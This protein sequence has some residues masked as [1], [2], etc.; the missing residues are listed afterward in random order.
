[1]TLERENPWIMS[2]RDMFGNPESHDYKFG[3]DFNMIEKTRRFY[4]LKDETLVMKKHVNMKVDLMADQAERDYTE[5]VKK[6]DRVMADKDHIEKTIGELDT[7]KNATLKKT[8]T[9]VTKNFTNIFGTL[10]PGA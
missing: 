6:K 7:L 1:M 5:L 2:E 8:F 9:E 4:K 10:L 3:P